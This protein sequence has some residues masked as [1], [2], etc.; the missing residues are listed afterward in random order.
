[1]STGATIAERVVSGF[2]LG[3]WLQRAL[4]MNISFP[5]TSKIASLRSAV[6]AVRPS[7]LP[8]PS[9][10]LWSFAPSTSPLVRDLE[11]SNQSFMTDAQC[12]F[13]A[14]QLKRHITGSF[15]SSDF[16]VTYDPPALKPVETE[17]DMPQATT[18]A[19]CKCAITNEA[20]P[21]P[22]FCKA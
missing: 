1:V 4:A 10:G 6:L 18:S 13:D 21:E 11:G 5:R 19:C 9:L 8:R 17:N 2:F 7:R 14:S 3:K 22:Q 15:E 12:A 20:A 16:N